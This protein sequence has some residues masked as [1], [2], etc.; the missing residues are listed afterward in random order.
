MGI[1]FSKQNVIIPAIYN[2]DIEKQLTDVHNALKGEFMSMGFP[3]NVTLRIA[4]TEWY[5]LVKYRQIAIPPHIIFPNPIS[6]EWIE[7]NYDFRHVDKFVMKKMNKSFLNKTPQQVAIFLIKDFNDEMLRARALFRWLAS[8]NLDK[9][10]YDKL[11]DN[12]M[13]YTLYRLKQ[14]NISYGKVLK[15]LCSFVNIYCEEVSGWAKHANYEIGEKINLNDKNFWNIIRI[16]GFWYLCDAN[17][18]SHK[19]F[20]G[21]KKYS[22]LQFFFKKKNLTSQKKYQYDNGYF[23]PNPEEFIYKHIPVLSKHQ[24]LARTVTL[25]EFEEMAYLRPAFF[26]HKLGIISHPKCTVFA[27]QSRNEILIGTDKEFPVIFAYTIFISDET[28]LD[29]GLVQDI[30]KETIDPSLYITIFQNKSKNLLII[31]LRLPQTAKYKLR[32]WVSK[33]DIKLK[34][35]DYKWCT[36]YIIKYTKRDNIYIPPFPNT[37]L[38]ELG[39]NYRARKCN[40]TNMFPVLGM[41]TSSN[42]NYTEIHFNGDDNEY[43]FSVEI[44][45]KSL[46]TITSYIVKS[47]EKA[48]YTLIFPDN[49]SRTIGKQTHFFRLKLRMEDNF[50]SY[51]ECSKNIHFKIFKKISCQFKIELKWYDENNEGHDLSMY[52]FFVNSY[53]DVTFY[54]NFPLPG[55]YKLEI[56]AKEL[57]SRKNYELIYNSY[58]YAIESNTNSFQFPIVTDKW[59]ISETHKILQPFRKLYSNEKVLIQIEGF[60][61]DEMIACRVND[62]EIFHFDLFN[63]IWECEIDTGENFGDLVIRAKIYKNAKFFT[64]ILIY[65]IFKNPI[66]KM[67]KPAIENSEIASEPEEATIENCETTSE[68]AEP[69]IGNS[70]IN[71]TLDKPAIDN[72]QAISKNENIDKIN[73]SQT[74]DISKN[75]VSDENDFIKTMKYVPNVQFETIENATNIEE[76]GEIDWSLKM[77]EVIYI[78]EFLPADDSDDGEDKTFK[79]NE[80]GNEKGKKEIVNNAEETTGKPGNRNDEK[81][82]KSQQQHNDQEDVAKKASDLK[83]A[84]E[85]KDYKKLKVAIDKASVKPINPLLIK[86]LSKANELKANLEKICGLQNRILKLDAKCIAELNQYNQPPA[87]VHLVIKSTL[88]ILSIDE[89]QTDEWKECRVFIKYACSYSIL[90]K[91]KA[92]KILTVHPAIILRA[93]Q[94]ICE[95][96]LQEVKEASAG[97]AAFYLWCK[98]NIDIYKKINKEE[99]GKSQPA[100]RKIQK[101]IFLS[102][103]HH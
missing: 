46:P 59:R 97:A 72:S 41:Y 50:Q 7:E 1:C 14:N 6:K 58:F 68:L 78:S 73:A 77:E 91:I 21:E 69:V 4:N 36:D 64:E 67:A 31:R 10:N 102:S 95:L 39:P 5:E 80:N 30:K 23:L 61:A 79:I 85:E 20:Q 29:T 86:D 66:M 25:Q 28:V 24:L 56:E 99:I 45:K 19:I 103:F 43:E 52:S 54:I 55:M 17:F 57:N 15:I 71:S 75:E 9:I 90:K 35:P 13:R 87:V 37:N 18:G 82:E 32:L 65:K 93:E 49:G 70:E 94:I 26:E 12:Q 98:G 42:K 81:E 62:N 48:N 8:I 76:I 34:E 60:K 40:F 27:E 44:T 47:E 92:L 84:Y 101:N 100:T 63:D 22:L 74:I 96:N 3:T 88:L 51:Q 89:G 33:D 53:E 83:K 38:S 16:N 11:M 2:P